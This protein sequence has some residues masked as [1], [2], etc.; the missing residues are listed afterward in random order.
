MHLK[1]DTLAHKLDPG[2]TVKN[3]FDVKAGSY[4]VRLVVRDAQ[5]L[6]SAESAAIEI[7]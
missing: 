4:L 2:V 5:G 7:P 1:D 3:G 6:L